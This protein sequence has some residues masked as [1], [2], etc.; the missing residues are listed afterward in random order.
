M[1]RA[2]LGDNIPARFDDAE[3]GAEI[4]NR[5]KEADNRLRWDG[6]RRGFYEVYYLKWNDRS[7]NTA[8]WIRYTLT[9]PL[10]EVADPYCELWGIFFDAAEPRRNF[11]LKKRFP[12]SELSWSASPF[13]LRIGEAELRHDTCRARI[14]DAGSGR[15]LAWDL[16]FDSADPTH[17][18]FPAEWLYERG[19]PRTKILSPHCNGRFSGVVE[20]GE[21]KI[22]LA[23]APGQQTHIWGTK[24]A[25]RWAWGHC[26]AFEEDPEAVWEGLTAQ[27]ALGPFASPRLSLF[28][29]KT[30]GEIHRF[31]ALPRWLLNRAAW[32]L[33]SWRFRFENESIRVEGEIDA[34]YESF[35][36]V[37]YM[38]PDGEELWCSN[39]KVAPIRLSLYDAF[40]KP[41][42]EL[43]SRTS[44]AVEFVD[45][46]VYEQVPVRI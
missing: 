31:N 13:A 12:I 21:R 40:G 1:L 32:D 18:F 17:R 28:Y 4:E 38:D 15:S 30:R 2:S 35:V 9:S 23:D 26:N 37:A 6:A 45:R 20:A 43:T 36:G 19:F 39:S 3:G 11:A 27:L 7:S 14:V 25:H 16:R 42:G 33:G 46:R 24:H 34:P 29:L 5:S 10:R 8:A 44:C 22:E 41:I